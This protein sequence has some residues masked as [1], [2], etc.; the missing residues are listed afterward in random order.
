MFPVSWDNDPSCNM[1][2]QSQL[3]V[4]GSELFYIK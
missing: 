4:D 1:Q 3:V 2:R